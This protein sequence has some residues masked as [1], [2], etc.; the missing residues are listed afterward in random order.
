MRKGNEPVDRHTV[1]HSDLVIHCHALDLALPPANLLQQIDQLAQRI[2]GLSVAQR[3]RVAAAFSN[4]GGA[5][6]DRADRADGYNAENGVAI[7][8]PAETPT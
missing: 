4:I 3:L 1:R 7:L 5:I 2:A 8:R 6:W